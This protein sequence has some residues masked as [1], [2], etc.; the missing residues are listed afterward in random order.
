MFAH[1]Y[2]ILDWVSAL[3]WKIFTEGTCSKPAYCT[4]VSGTLAGWGWVGGGG[5]REPERD[6]PEL[7]WDIEV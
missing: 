7:E 4:V 5:G 3:F 1:I 6:S 2:S